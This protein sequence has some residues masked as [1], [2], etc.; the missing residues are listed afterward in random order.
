MRARQF[1]GDPGAPSLLLCNDGEDDAVRDCV[2]VLGTLN[3]MCTFLGIFTAPARVRA[4]VLILLP[5]KGSD[6]DIE[7]VN[8]RLGRGWIIICCECR[9]QMKLGELLSHTRVARAPSPAK[10]A[11]LAF[12]FGKRKS[13]H[14]HPSLTSRNTRCNSGFRR[15]PAYMEAP[16]NSSPLAKYRYRRRLPHLQK[17]DAALFVTFCT[18]GRMILPERARDL[19]LEHC[20]REAGI[21]AM[22]G[23]GARP[24]RAARIRLH[25]VV[26]MPDHVHLLLTPLRDERWL[27]VS[28][29]RHSSMPEEHDGSSDQSTA[30]HLRAG[31]GRGIVRSC[32]AVGREFEGE[33]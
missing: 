4:P 14:V 11:S 28:A 2:A 15:S 18:G 17:A 8:L 20:L 22:A 5:R 16:A 10:G 33:V 27:A 29:G 30:W 7:T 12:Q 32:A 31:L 26:V 9:G 25:A 19:V 1:E 13:H 21:L 3:C 6:V 24:T 23:E